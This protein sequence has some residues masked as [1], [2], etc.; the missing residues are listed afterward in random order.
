[1]ALT[2]SSYIV[3][4]FLR[5]GLLFLVDRRGLEAYLFLRCRFDDLGHLGFGF[6]WA[7]AELLC[8]SPN[9]LGMIHRADSGSRRCLGRGHDLMVLL[10]R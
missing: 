1:M 9:P 2:A 10:Q 5:L 6:G 7:G 4:A 8:W 3:M